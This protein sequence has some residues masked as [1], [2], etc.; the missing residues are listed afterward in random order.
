MA[1][2]WNVF[3][4]AP[5]FAGIRSALIGTGNDDGAVDLLA[6]TFN[7]L[8]AK[9]TG[10]APTSAE[11]AEMAFN[12]SEAEKNREFQTL[13]SNT[14]YQRATADMQAAGLNPAMMYGS[15]ASPAS[16]PSGNAASSSVGAGADLSALISAFQVPAQIKNLQAQTKRIEADTKNVEADTILKEENV[17]GARISNDFAEDTYD[18][19]RVGVELANR[20]SAADEKKIYKQLE[21]ADEDIK[22]RI[23]QAATE[24]ERKSLIMAEKL[25]SEANA[26]QIT[27]LLPYRQALL[28]AQTVAE[29]NLAALYAIQAAY[30][31]KLLKDG[32]L[33]AMIDAM[34]AQAT[35]EESKAAVEDLRSR[36]R[37]GKLIPT[38]DATSLLGKI[39]A[40]VVNYP[41]AVIS[42]TLD[43]AGPLIGSVVGAF[44]G[45]KTAGIAADAAKARSASAGS[46]DYGF[47]D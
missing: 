1:K 16:T 28:D 24:E 42:N 11:K 46:Y 36:I 35:T 43:A 18:A 45:V 37:T 21:L 40:G 3:K 29:K 44:A 20:L 23:K 22:L 6:D 41:V 9:Y 5:Q 14:A 19:R 39:G 7:S 10:N 15:S 12:A 38:S 17:R 33:D 13:M 8:V 32:Y 47:N 26:R 4:S 34:K 2:F 25:L 31:N 30:Q 27:E